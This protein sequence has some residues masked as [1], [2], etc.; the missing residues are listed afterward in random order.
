[1][2]VCQWNEEKDDFEERLAN[3]QCYQDNSDQWQ[4]SIGQIKH[5]RD[6]VT[7]FFHSR[8]CLHTTPFIKVLKMNGQY[9]S[10]ANCCNLRKQN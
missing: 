5:E 6:E 8:L 7:I 1:V 10:M 4:L 3:L 9:D 2:N